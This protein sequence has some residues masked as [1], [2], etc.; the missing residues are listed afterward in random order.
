MVK[1]LQNMPPFVPVFLVKIILVELKAKFQ[2]T[3]NFLKNKNLTPPPLLE[4]ILDPRLNIISVPV[5]MKKMCSTLFLPFY[6]FSSAIF[7]SANI[8]PI[9]KESAD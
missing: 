3:S 4:K 7:Q 5:T 8:V 2:K 9:F 1:T 6:F